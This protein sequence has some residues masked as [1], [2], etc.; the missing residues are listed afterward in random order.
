MHGIVALRGKLGHTT[1]STA[2]SVYDRYDY[3]P[4]KRRLNDALATYNFYMNDT[5]FEKEC[6]VLEKRFLERLDAALTSGSTEISGPLVDLN[7]KRQGKAWKAILDQLDALDGALRRAATRPSE[8]DRRLM[9][10]KRLDRALVRPC[11]SSS[12]MAPPMMH[13]G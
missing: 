6:Q 12:S 10:P 2:G 7:V 5:Y 13:S 4:F 3:N 8:A 11:F 1:I 9:E